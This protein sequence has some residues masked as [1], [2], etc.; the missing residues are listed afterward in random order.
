M[1]V[2]ETGR[3]EKQPAIISFAKIKAASRCIQKLVKSYKKVCL[4][5][6]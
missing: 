3:Q 1:Y 6:V 4:D 5:A 2:R